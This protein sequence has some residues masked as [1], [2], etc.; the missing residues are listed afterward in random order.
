MAVVDLNMN[1]L[2]MGDHGVGKTQL[3]QKFASTEPLSIQQPADAH[4]QKYVSSVT[5]YRNYMT[6]SEFM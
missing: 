2:L 4:R 3:L 6:R 1:V 5:S